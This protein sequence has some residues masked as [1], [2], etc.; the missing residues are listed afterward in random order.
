MEHGDLPG[1]CHI[2]RKIMG[3]SCSTPLDHGFRGVPRGVE[4]GLGLGRGV[5]GSGGGG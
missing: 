5:G 1:K 2:T 4:E 3:S